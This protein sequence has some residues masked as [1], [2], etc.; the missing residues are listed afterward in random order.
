MKIKEG[1]M[2][3]DVAGSYV[4]VPM[5]KEAADFNGMI[6]LNETGAFLWKQLEKG[7]TREELLEALLKEY[8]V[9]EE[10]A[11]KG[12]EKFLALIEENDFAK[13]S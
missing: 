1:F 10:R 7:C 5:G 9:P 13:D 3:R 6:T 4:V 8:D 12:I 2:L 11:A